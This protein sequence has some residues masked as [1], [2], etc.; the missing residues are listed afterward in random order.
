MIH[1]INTISNFMHNFNM[2]YDLESQ[3]KALY[4]FI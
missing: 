3:V 1:F 4:Y 2:I